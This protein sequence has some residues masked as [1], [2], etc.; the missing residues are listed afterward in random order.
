MFTENNGTKLH[1]TISHKM[2]MTGLMELNAGP[3]TYTAM[4]T[5][6]GDLAQSLDVN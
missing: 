2:V 5:H 3:L 6:T 1:D 4:T